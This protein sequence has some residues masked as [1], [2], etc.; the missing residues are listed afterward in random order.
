MLSINVKGYKRACAPLTGGVSQLFVGDAEDFNFTEGAAVNGEKTGYSAIG[1]RPGA[2]SVAV[3]AQ[4]ATSSVTV[5][6]LA[7]NNTVIIVNVATDTA[8]NSYGTEIRL[9][10]Y[11]KSS[12]EA[13]TA[14]VAAKLADLI[15]AGP[16]G[17]SNGYVAVSDGEDLN[18]TA[19]ATSGAAHNG[20][21]LN[22]ITNSPG[23]PDLD[24][25][26]NGGVTGS[27]GGAFL[28]EINSLEDSITMKA[29]QGYG[30]GSSEYAYEIKAK[31]AELCQGMTNFTTKIDTAASCGQLV[32]V[33]VMNNGK[34]LVAGERYVNNNQIAKWR[35]RQD[36][37]VLDT[38]NV[39]KSF[40]GG[41]LS[42]KG[43]Y[44]RGPFEFTAGISALSPFIAP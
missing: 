12:S 36:G 8:A 43:T 6:T 4:R 5:T 41:D 13:T 22:L 38:G 18:I 2:N 31:A 14:A 11:T 17:G 9:C 32:F 34:I 27:A 26:F 15:N 21:Y 30:D 33:L 16:Y 7:N 44:L 39:F 23:T 37:T 42:F 10:E 29:T 40:N 1:Y 24:N 28:Y 20:K 3:T 19:P 25:A 35:I